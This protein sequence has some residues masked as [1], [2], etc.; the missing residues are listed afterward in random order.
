MDKT[1]EISIEKYQNLVKAA[2]ILS[3]FTILY[4]TVEGL[5]SVKFGLDDDTLALLGFGVDS[6]VE[7]ISG[8][9][10]FHMIIRMQKESIEQRDKFE[11]SALRIT[12]ASFFLLTAGLILGALT[13]LINENK[14]ETAF[15]GII[16]SII[17]ILTMYI[18]L[19]FKLK[20]GTRLN[21]D[22]IIADANCTKTCFYLSL[23]LLVSS[24][25]YEIFKIGYLDIAGTIGIAYFA[26]REGKESYEKANSNKLT[27][28]CEGDCN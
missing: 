28:S 15:V 17:S 26:F 11:K 7:V 19:K 27:C 4:N 16:V 25:S 8:L 5:V 9:G 24:L 6:F 22:A 21:S 3:L 18:L 13:N 1:K 2:L 12:S 23:I 14:P 10:I 20:I